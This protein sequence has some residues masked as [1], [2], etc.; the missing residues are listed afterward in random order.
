MLQKRHKNTLRGPRLTSQC[1][2]APSLPMTD[3]AKPA[4]EIPTWFA[5]RLPEPG[6]RTREIAAL[7]EPIPGWLD[8]MTG[9]ALYDLVLNRAPNATVVEIGVY[10]GRSAAWLASAVKDRGGGRLHAVDHWR[11]MTFNELAAPEAF[12]AAGGYD[13]LYAEFLAHMARIGVADVIEPHR[14]ASIEAARAWPRTHGI[15]VLHID[16]DHSFGGA[17]EDFEWW[18]PAVVPGGFIVFDDVPSWAGPARV[19]QELP[20]WFRYYGSL[21]NKWIV[22][23]VPA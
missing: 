19:V 13:A 1:A 4:L 8:A 22:E 21:P 12:A 3:P 16:G 17:R 15:G 11:L 18:S 20:G 9:P 6:P 2:S 23:R 5:H 10:K 14:M 7:A